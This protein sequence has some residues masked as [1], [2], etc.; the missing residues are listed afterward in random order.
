[1]LHYVGH[2]CDNIVIAKQEWIL[3]NM[4][5]FVPTTNHLDL[6]S[7]NTKLTNYILESLLPYFWCD[8]L[9]TNLLQYTNTRER[10][11]ERERERDCALH[12][13]NTLLYHGKKH[14]YYVYGNHHLVER[15]V[16][17]CKKEL[18]V[19]PRCWPGKERL[20]SQFNSLFRLGVKQV[21]DIVKAPSQRILEFIE[22]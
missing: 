7:Q 20:R 11:R 6:T 16:I 15:I 9:W 12:V 14:S 17:L 5:D 13:F 8:C 1:M 22:A 21:G 10:E 2:K 19:S 3:A 18:L 4:L